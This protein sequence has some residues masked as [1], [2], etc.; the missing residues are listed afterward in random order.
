MEK[1]D[2]PVRTD[3][4]SETSQS[5]DT[6]SLEFHFPLEKRA[7]SS[8]GSQ[9]DV[10]WLEIESLGFLPRRLPRLRINNS[11]HWNNFPDFT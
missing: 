10:G 3:P 6:Q 2:Q 1:M 11:N 7:L 5:G 9:K 4:F 8:R